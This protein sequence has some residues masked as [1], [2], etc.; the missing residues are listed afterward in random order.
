MSQTHQVLSDVFGFQEFQGDQEAIIHSVL[1][2]E[3]ALVLMPTGGGK[4]LCYQIPSILR[5]G[6]GVIISPLI[7]LM[8]EQVQTLQEMGIKAR[9]FNSSLE[10][11]S[12]KEVLSELGSGQLDL[13]YV[14]P[15]SLTSDFFRDLIKDANIALFAVD[16][17][18]CVSQ[19]G[20]DF[21]P[22]YLRIAEITSEVPQ[23]P[24]IALT[25]TADE[26]TRTEIS[27]N[28][29]LRNPQSFISSFDRPNITYRLDLKN[30]PS[31]Q[32]LRWLKS[33]HPEESGIVYCLSRAKVDQVAEFLASHGMN[34]LPY[35]AGM[36]HDIRSENQKRFQDENDLI[37]VATIAFGMGIDKPDVRFVAHLD[38]PSSMEA[39]YQETGRAGRDGKTAE[40]WLV[41]GLQDVV[42]RRQMIEKSEGNERFKKIQTQKLEEMLAFCESTHCRRKII[43]GYFGEERATQCGNCDTCL[44]PVES[45]EGLV[46]AQKFL[47]CVARTGQNFGAGHIIDVLRGKETEKVFRFNHQELST[48]GVGADL[49]DFQWR[50]VLRQL[51]VQGYVEIGQEYSNLLLTKESREL[52]K[53]NREFYLRNDTKSRM[54]KIT[55][56]KKKKKKKP[57]PELE[58]RF[59][60]SQIE[61][62]EKIRVWRKEHADSLGIPAFRV[63]SDQTLYSLVEI[64]PRTQEELLSVFGFGKMK[65]ERHGE[66][67]LGLL[68]EHRS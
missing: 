63:F 1:N 56:R 12:R 18:H 21:R 4:S 67:I 27:K 45:I 16:E 62:S 38:M 57:Q 64:N 42:Q 2:N 19:W 9:Y 8:Q 36:N 46:P 11:E 66:E 10:F 20:H 28:L 26:R 15:E 31:Q 40:A 44:E 53:G 30:S 68:E 60:D 43:L 65:T 23:A 35:H 49:D 61:L 47:S 48:F 14:A 37:I 39:Y 24:V 58:M 3:D 33:E 54:Q 41:Y 29:K 55:A 51:V 5:H 25:A 50:S 6:T 34:A 7:A 59:S 32:L 22:E 17:A 13:L 52:L